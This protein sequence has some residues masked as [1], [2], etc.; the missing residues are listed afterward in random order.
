MEEKQKG[1]LA[2]IRSIFSAIKNNNF[3]QVLVVSSLMNMTPTY[4]ALVTAFLTDVLKFTKIDLANLS[5]YSTVF[6]ILALY[7]Y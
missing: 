5:C 6:Y 2:E 1:S 3:I 7:L 4:D